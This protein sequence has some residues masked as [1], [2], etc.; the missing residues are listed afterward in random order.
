MADLRVFT[1]SSCICEV[2]TRFHRS[3]DDI[4]NLDKVQ[5]IQY[6]HLC[7][8]TVGSDCSRAHS[9]LPH[10]SRIIVLT[11]ALRPGVAAVRINVDRSRCIES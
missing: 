11:R 6:S 7:H 10:G 5:M 2:R 3:C 8:G 1:S 9:E 4:A